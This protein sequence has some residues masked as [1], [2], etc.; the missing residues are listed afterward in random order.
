VIQSPHVSFL[1]LAIQPV[2]LASDKLNTKQI[3]LGLKGFLKA[4][5]VGYE[6]PS[7]IL[8]EK[9]NLSLH[10]VFLG[11]LGYIDTF[12]LQSITP[13]GAS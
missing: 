8:M 6:Q 2:I 13:I 9:N 3:F 4:R 1:K 7:N 11:H 5:E 12:T 10:I